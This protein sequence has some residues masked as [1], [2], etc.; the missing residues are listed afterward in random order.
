MAASNRPNVDA[1]FL[2]LASLIATRST[3]LRRSVGCVL[4]DERNH[5]LATGY[6]GVAPGRPH[7][8]AAVEGAPVYREK[9]PAEINATAHP[10]DTGKY[11]KESPLVY[12]NACPGHDAPSGTNLEGCGAIH[13]EENALVQ[14]KDPY[15][16]HTVYC[17]TEPCVRCTRMLQVT[18]AK[19][20]V[21]LEVYAGSGR[22]LW[23]G[24]GLTWQVPGFVDHDQALKA[25]AGATALVT[26]VQKEALSRGNQG[27]QAAPQ[28][29]LEA[30]FPGP[31][32]S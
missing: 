31:L 4:V 26:R 10:N 12:P 8:N 18:G 28:P 2:A 27:S 24:D 23:K 14:C 7:C 16:I 17:T 3:C 20:V 11:V 22:K 29:R 13:A 1:Y 21:A 32:E 5:V 30:D 19:R 9:T 6:N 15:A 25:L